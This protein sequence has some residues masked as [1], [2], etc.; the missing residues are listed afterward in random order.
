MTLK[1]R[2]LLQYWLPAV[3]W[4]AVVLSASSDLFSGANT[5]SVLEAIV[6]ALFGQVS[7]ERLAIA[8][9]LVRKLAHLTEYGILAWLFYRAL[10]QM[11]TFWNLRWATLAIAGVLVVAIA[12]EVHQHFVPSRVGSPVDVLIDVAGGAVALLIV[13]RIS[14][15]LS[16]VAA[17]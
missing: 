16:S 8:H 5:G 17:S 10:R 15:R 1:A 9:F 14:L 11:H 4:A 12:D 3:L 13:R 7:P 6:T 2:I